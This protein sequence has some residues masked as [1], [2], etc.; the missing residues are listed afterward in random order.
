MCNSANHQR[1]TYQ[2]K[3]RKRSRSFV[4]P[5]IARQAPLSRQEYWS[6]LPFPLSN[7]YQ[8]N[9]EKKKKT[10]MR[11]HLIPVRMSII[12]KTT[13]NKCSQESRER[14]LLSTT[15]RNVN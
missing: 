13:N 6:G 10:T 2:R 11:Y 7:A 8:N 4:Q 12:K 1:N 9:D 15:G 14:E 5:H 3:E